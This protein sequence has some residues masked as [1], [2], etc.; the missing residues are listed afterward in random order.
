MPPKAGE[1]QCP[2][3]GSPLPRSQ[4]AWAPSSYS[5]RL[6]PQSCPDFLNL[7][8]RQGLPTPSRLH[9]SALPDPGWPRSHSSS[10]ASASPVPRLLR[11]APPCR[12][13]RCQTGGEATASPCSHTSGRWLPPRNK[14]ARHRRS[15]SADRNTGSSLG[16]LGPQFLKIRESKPQK[17]SFRFSDPRPRWVKRAT[18]R[19][20][21]LEVSGR[22]SPLEQPPP[23]LTVATRGGGRRGASWRKLSLCKAVATVPTRQA[24]GR[25]R[26]RSTETEDRTGAL[27]WQVSKVAAVTCVGAFSEALPACDRL[28]T[29]KHEGAASLPWAGRAVWATARVNQQQGRKDNLRGE[30]GSDCHLLTSWKCRARLP[31]LETHLIF[32]VKAK[33]TSFS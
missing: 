24:D 32:R 21:S 33:I 20:P 29:R 16:P 14:K 26:V 5:A 25:V 2:F 8:S 22:Q 11:H 31:F 27:A 13:Q 30:K 4:T 6:C 19:T 23:D 7:L 1:F 3:S 17:P 18:T 12:H 9:L 15:L 10:P 28:F